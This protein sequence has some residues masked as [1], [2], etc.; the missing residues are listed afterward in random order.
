[1][2]KTLK[3]LLF[4]ALI[5]IAFA[6]SFSISKYSSNKNGALSFRVAKPIA[7]V[8][9]GNEIYISNYGQRPLNFSIHN[10]DTSNRVSEVAMNYVIKMKVSQANAPLK[11]KLYR[12]KAD[13]SEE[14][15]SISVNNGVI[16]S[17]SQLSMNAGTKETQNYKLEFIYDKTSNVNLASNISITIDV[18]AIQKRI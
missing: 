7:R 10:F 5:C 11:Y 4:L 13:N 18:D 1:M 3:I 15:I 8:S 2:K 12:I 6:I 16:T 9:M 14:E 17:T